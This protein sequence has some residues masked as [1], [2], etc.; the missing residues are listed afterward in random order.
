ML[1]ASFNSTR[2]NSRC[3]IYGKPNNAAGVNIPG[4][5]RD[6]TSLESTTNYSRSSIWITVAHSGTSIYPGTSLRTCC[7]VLGD[8]L[9]SG[10]PTTAAVSPL[11]I[12][13]L[14][15]VGE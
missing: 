4:F 3:F 6:G 9:A 11:Q 7:P 1:L 13:C 15:V 8:D 12:A 14:S 2:S 5:T 10:T